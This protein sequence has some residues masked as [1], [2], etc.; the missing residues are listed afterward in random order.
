VA[1][2]MTVAQLF[3][4]LGFEHA[5][6]EIDDAIKWAL[7]ELQL[8]RQELPETLMNGYLLNI[9][10]LERAKARIKELEAQLEATQTKVRDLKNDLF[11]AEVGGTNRD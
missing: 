1:D 10:R 6:G 8:R 7:V 11:W 4:R 5:A 3:Q 9:E 2:Q